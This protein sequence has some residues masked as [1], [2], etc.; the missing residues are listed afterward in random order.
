MSWADAPVVYQPFAPKAPTNDVA[1][2]LRSRAAD[3][4]GSAAAIHDRIARVDPGV[5]VGEVEMA[6][7]LID[8][9][10]A[11]PRFR[12]VLSGSFAVIAL[13]LAAGGLYAVLSHL[14]GQRTHEIG[15]RMALGAHQAAILRL[16][17]SEGLRLAIAGV[18]VGLLAAFSLTRILASFLFGVR[19][20]DPLTVSVVSLVL[21]AAALLA[22]LLPARRAAS[23]DP[24]SALRCD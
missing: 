16:T 20:R 12:A 21:L 1:L 3:L 22:T 19:A 10:V 18:A 8:R 17:M 14:A 6:Q 7:R 4:G 9:Y 2:L 11:H 15:V 24:M 23:V 13:L 5:V